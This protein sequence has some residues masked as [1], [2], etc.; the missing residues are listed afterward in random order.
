MLIGLY[1][2]F[3][4]LWEVCLWDDC[5]LEEMTLF[6]HAPLYEPGSLPTR[7]SVADLFTI[8]PV[9]SAGELRGREP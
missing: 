8:I 2:T 9:T 3:I 7:V 4:G 5:H 1:C 6:L